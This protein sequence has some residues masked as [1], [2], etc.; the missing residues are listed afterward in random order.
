MLSNYPAKVLLSF[1]KN[2]HI[3]AYLFLFLFG[4]QLVALS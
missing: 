3:L 1:I 4:I 2:L